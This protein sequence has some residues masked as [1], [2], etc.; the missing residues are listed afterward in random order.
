MPHVD[1]WIAAK[2]KA[3]EAE[4]ERHKSTAEALTKIVDKTIEIQEHT[5]DVAE[6]IQEKVPEVCKWKPK[7]T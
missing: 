2:V 3:K 5:R 4:A 7:Q 6:K 1:Q